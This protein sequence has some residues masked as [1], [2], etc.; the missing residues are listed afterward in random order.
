MHYGENIYIAE[1]RFTTFSRRG[2]LS[3]PGKRRKIPIRRGEKVYS[4][5][6]VFCC[7]WK[8]MIFQFLKHVFCFCAN[9]LLYTLLSNAFCLINIFEQ[10]FQKGIEYQ[11]VMFFMCIATRWLKHSRRAFDHN[12][13]FI[14]RVT[15]DVMPAC[16]S[17]GFSSII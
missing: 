7:F 16:R 8:C 13:S 4:A 10:S 2:N 14:V 15:V 6:K 12:H 11:L 5:A 1:E 9:S 17:T 3:Q